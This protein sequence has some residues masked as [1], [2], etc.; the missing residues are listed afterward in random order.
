VV[1]RIAEGVREGPHPGV[2][3]LPRAGVAGAEALGHAVRPHRP[4]LV[5]VAANPDVRQ[6]PELMIRGDLRL[7]HMAVVVVDR[8]PLGIPVV[9]L[10]GRVGLQ[11]EV[12]VDE[13]LHREVLA[14]GSVSD[15]IPPASRG[16]LRV[17]PHQ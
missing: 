9:E 15:S 12:V 2:K 7:R 1:E 14:T 8:L 6:V 11:Q 5:V 10:P 17:R 16:S 3:L 4:P 13:G